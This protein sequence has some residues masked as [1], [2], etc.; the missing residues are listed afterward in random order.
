M[1]T[2]PG[3]MSS[4]DGPPPFLFLNLAIKEAQ[5]IKPLKG[6][7]NNPFQIPNVLD[8]SDNNGDAEG[9]P[10]SGGCTATGKPGKPCPELWEFVDEGGCN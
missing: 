9:P 8:L 6:A 4:P 7:K 1:I 10:G 2:R 3:K 5:K